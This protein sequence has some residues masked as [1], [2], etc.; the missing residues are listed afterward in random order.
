MANSG[1][2]ATITMH[3][4]LSDKRPLR[5]APQKRPKKVTCCVIFFSE[6]LSQ[7]KSHSMMMVLFQKLLS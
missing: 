5:K 2:K 7:T 4:Y 6:A 3:L 1:K